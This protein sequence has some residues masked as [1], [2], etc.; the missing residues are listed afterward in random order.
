[1]IFL[2]TKL[3]KIILIFS[4]FIILCT[5]IISIYIGL[6]LVT[7]KRDIINKTPKD[8]GLKYENI[9]FN[10]K[11]NS[12]LLK[13]WWIPAQNDNK[14]TKSKKTIIFSH[15]Y[16][17]NR[18]LMDIEVINLAKRLSK[19]NY[20]VL[21]FDFRGEGESEGKIVTLGALEK[22]DLLSAIDFAKNTKHSEKIGLIGWS[23]GAATSLLVGEN[24][25]DV[26]AIIAD[27]PFSSLKGYLKENLP[28]WTN[29]PNFPFTPIILGVLP[30]V[31]NINIKSV[32]T[33]NAVSK[34][35]NKEL[36]LIH[37]KGDSVIP[38][39][40]SEKIYKSCKNKSH[41]KLWITDKADHIRSY[42][43]HKELYE[44]NIINFFNLNLK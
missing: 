15:G 31:I 6:N 41:I 11:H 17:D 39:T 3:S 28:Y 20:N 1:M 23:M 7:P 34:Y 35:K 8:Y 22:Y 37:G 21:V 10:S 40:E 19:E 2:K 38:Y 16:G 30:S 24:S 9:S 14:E 42:K 13:G 18:A 43:M 4:L 26:Q 44:E 12:V 32:D 5:L 25:K 27:S 33:I 36:L 29:L